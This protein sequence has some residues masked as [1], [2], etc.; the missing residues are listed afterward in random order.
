M[1]NGNPVMEFESPLE[2][3]SESLVG[4]N[5]SDDCSLCSVPQILR[6][7]LRLGLWETNL[8]E[9]VEVDMD[10]DPALSSCFGRDREDHALSTCFGRNREEWNKI[11]PQDTKST[12]RTLS[13]Y[14][15]NEDPAN[16]STDED[17]NEDED[18]LDIEHE[19]NLD[20]YPRLISMAQMKQIQTQAL[21]PSCQIMTWTR[22][23]SLS[24]DGC[25]FHTFLKRCQKF[26]NTL[27]VIKTTAGDILGGFADSTWSRSTNSSERKS[28]KSFYGGGKCFLFATNPDLSVGEVEFDASMPM[29]NIDEAEK[30]HLY[31]WSGDNTYN[32]ICDVIEEKIAMGGGGSFG[33]IVQD[34]FAYGSTGCSCTFLNPPLTK[35]MDGGFQILDLEVY[36]FKSMVERMFKVHG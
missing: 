20:E 9:T 32:Q 23:Y 7:F 5:I 4:E 8:I 18:P 26:Q 24:R 6:N 1:A 2:H 36:G 31:K 22:C 19:L 16:Y 28:S 3:N 33:W 13:S 21:S 30:L 27:V 14:S 35:G 12:N 29:K 34:N 15:D 17:E 11:S 25:S 10:N